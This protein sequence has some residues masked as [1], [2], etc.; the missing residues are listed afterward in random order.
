MKLEH[1]RCSGLNLVL[2][3]FWTHGSEY[4]ACYLSVTRKVN[5]V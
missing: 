2:L 5:I 4:C 1:Q 3:T